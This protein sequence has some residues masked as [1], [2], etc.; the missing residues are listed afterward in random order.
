VRQLGIFPVKAG[1]FG[2]K[3]E[4]ANAS[5]P[6]PVLSIIANLKVSPLAG[7]NVLSIS[8]RGED[9]QHLHLASVVNAIIASYQEYRREMERASHFDELEALTQSEKK[10]REDLETLKD[11]YSAMREGSPL[12][13]QGKDPVGVQRVM[14]TKLGEALI[15]VKKHRMEL[16]NHH[17]QMVQGAKFASAGEGD[18]VFV[19]GPKLNAQA[20]QPTEQRASTAGREH[21]VSLL[22]HLPTT[23]WAAFGDPE[24]IQQELR[25]AQVHEKELDAQFGD[26]HPEIKAVREQI[27]ALNALLDDVVDAGPAIIEQEIATAVMHE[28]E[29]TKLYDEEFEKAK[30]VD[31]FMI[32]EQQKLESIQRTQ[33]M[34]D[35]ILTQ[36]RE[37]QV[38]EAA[39]AAGRS[40][41]K[42]SV[43]ESPALPAAKVWPQ[44][45]LL[46]AAS[47]VIGLLFGFGLILI[48]EFNTLVG[49]YPNGREE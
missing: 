19:S 35:A 2:S 16:E 30:Q 22:A 25:L 43:L 23:A 27:E 37:L 38:A 1:D 39:L 15:D 7:T 45:S 13:G 40:A 4:V 33:T 17:R 28:N 6:D 46:L 14:L 10:L 36:L 12:L 29:L 26:K 31:N 41:V 49:S 3:V 44:S 34:H 8:F 24:A 11:D 32:K 9:S 42:V 20:G 5:Q 21:L 47:G 18:V 48:T